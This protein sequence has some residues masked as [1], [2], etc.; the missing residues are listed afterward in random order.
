MTGPLLE[1]R[2]LVKEFASS[3]RAPV[4]KAV[5]GVSLQIG[6]GQVYGLVGESG[7]GKTTLVRCLVRLWDPTSGQ[8]RFGGQDV[9]AATG[10]TL[11][12]IR[13]DIGLVFQNPVAAMNPRLSVGDVV[14]EPLRT[15]GRLRGPALETRVLALLDQVGLARVHLDRRAHELSGG[16]A[17]RVGIARAL[18]TRPR[19]LVLDEPTSA[20]DVSVQAQ[21]L[22]LLAD[23]REEAGLTY[24]L[25]SHDL[26]VV[27]YLADRVGVMY[28]GRLVEDG[29]AA[30]VLDAP[31]HPYTQALLAAAPSVSAVASLD[32]VLAGEVPGAAGLPSGCRFHPR[33]AVRT[34]LERSLPELAQR[35]RTEDPRPRAD[36]TGRQVACHAVDPHAMAPA[37]AEPAPTGERGAR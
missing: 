27:R 37:A 7:S 22:N 26:D 11:R 13:R 21:V 33:C 32:A 1:V 15:H 36:R 5:D 18:A 24:L 31:S 6:P 17:Q 34:A 30:T 28:L 2:D 29:A 19:L 9:H 8:V 16:Q 35:C 14:G 20:L 10:E 3:K 23:L 12:R 25:V 4:I